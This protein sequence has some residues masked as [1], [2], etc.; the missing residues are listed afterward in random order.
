MI[1][2]MYSNKAEIKET[3]MHMSTVIS[4]AFSSLYAPFSLN[5]HMHTHIYEYLEEDT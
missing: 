3:Y 4:N 2:T 1:N 5:I